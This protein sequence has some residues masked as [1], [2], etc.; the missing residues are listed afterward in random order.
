M[1]TFFESKKIKA[2]REYIKGLVA[3]AKCDN[4]IAKSEI[5]CIYKIGEKKGLSRTDIY[6][7]MRENQSGKLI[8]PESMDDRFEMLYDMIDVMLADGI[9]DDQE[10]DFCIDLAEKLGV[11]S[12]TCGVLVTKMT[13]GMQS[14]IKKEKLYKDATPFLV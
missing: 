10:M 14:G 3:L 11:R 4:K 13:S 2:N 9:I 7:I 1:V 5:E 6:S 8:I 12:A